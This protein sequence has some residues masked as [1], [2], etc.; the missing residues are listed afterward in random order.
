MYTYAKYFKRCILLIAL[1]D[2]IANTHVNFKTVFI[3]VHIYLIF[4]INIYYICI[5]IFKLLFTN[6]CKHVYHIYICT[7]LRKLI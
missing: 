1:V 7:H 4:N 2:Y 6:V 5:Q 3:S